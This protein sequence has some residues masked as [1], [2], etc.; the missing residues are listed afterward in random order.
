VFHINSKV[1]GTFHINT[2]HASKI[3]IVSEGVSVNNVH[4]D[5]NSIGS[6]NRKKS[7]SQRDKV[8]NT[9]IQTSQWDRG[10]QRNFKGQQRNSVKSS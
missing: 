6:L 3:Q 5:V 4:D 9:V 1:K 8:I 7:T 2:H 10:Q